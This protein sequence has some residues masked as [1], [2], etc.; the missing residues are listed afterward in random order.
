VAFQNKWTSSFLFKKNMATLL[1]KGV[2]ISQL[3]GAKIFSFPFD[4]DEWP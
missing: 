2:V 4:F 3:L 1:E